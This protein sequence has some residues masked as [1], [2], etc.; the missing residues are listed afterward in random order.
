MLNITLNRP[1]PHLKQR[2]FMYSPAKHKMVRAGRR[3]GKTSGLANL[4][5]ERAARGGIVSY[6]APTAK[7]TRTFW[8]ELMKI[9]NPLVRRKLATARV[10]PHR[11]L[12]L[13]TGGEVSAQTAWNVDSLRGG[14]ADLLILDEFQLMNE[15]VWLGAAQ[16][17]LL[18]SDGDA[19][20]L[21]TPA[22]IY[23]SEVSKAKNKH[24]AS[25]LFREKEP[26]P[27]WE[28]FTFTSWD[29]PYIPRSAL[30]R[31]KA[32]MTE[33]HYLTEIMAQDATEDPKALWKRKD[34]RYKSDK[35]E[36]DYVVVGVDPSGS[37]RDETG[38]IVAGRKGDTC[39]VM[40]DGT[41]R[42]ASPEAW[43]RQ[44]AE[45]Y[46]EYDANTIVAERNFGGEMVRRVIHIEDPAM[47]VKVIQAS[48]SKYA[49]A[50]PIARMYERAK[51][52]HAEAF[53][54]LE[55]QMCQWVPN[56]K[57]KSPDRLDANVWA[58]TELTN[59]AELIMDIELL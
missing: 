22:S 46:R 11:A 44:V 36:Y 8:T 12:E 34:I 45:L 57:H 54:E 3:G 32:Q 30:H 23:D 50:E 48:R 6:A 28:L 56:S 51:I 19:V 16:P 1:K 40:Y 25:D 9:Y 59:H 53:G 21:Y 27:D 7:Q 41:L 31:R 10:A 29:N 24:H 14:R 47:P 35:I 43:G 15:D 18:D 58:L 37:M 17:M 38:I 2:E 13:P 52:F 4:A 49:R 20:F 39:F 42:R 33:V 26:D 55:D 5:A